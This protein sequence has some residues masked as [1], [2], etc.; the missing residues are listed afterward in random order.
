MPYE[1]DVCLSY[2]SFLMLAYKVVIVCIRGKKNSE[3]FKN[4][5]IYKPCHGSIVMLA[6][7]S[8]SSAC[9]ADVY[10]TAH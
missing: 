1:S 9:V 7:S 4:G 10:R 2:F 3:L 5:I 8:Y 6:V